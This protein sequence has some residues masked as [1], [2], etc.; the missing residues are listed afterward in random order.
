MTLKDFE[1]IYVNFYFNLLYRVL[2][3]FLT[4]PCFLLKMCSAKISSNALQKTLLYIKTL[5]CKTQEALALDHNLIIYEVPCDNLAT[6]LG[7][8]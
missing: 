6:L 5:E 3:L 1:S 2:R 8:W 4:V 7:V